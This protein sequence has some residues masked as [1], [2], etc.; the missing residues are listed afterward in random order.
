MKEQ[1]RVFDADLIEGR[2]EERSD[3]ATPPSTL[4]W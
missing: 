3:E 4:A 2:C 1:N